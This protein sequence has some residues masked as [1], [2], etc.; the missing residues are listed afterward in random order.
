MAPPVGGW[1]GV[2]STVR[3]WQRSW[4]GVSRL[5]YG[6]AFGV[7]F[8]RFVSADIPELNVKVPPNKYMGNLTDF[9]SQ[10]GGGTK[11]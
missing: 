10:G 11:P 7:G 3:L 6:C 2:L 9:Y 1:A 8:G 5:T 4:G